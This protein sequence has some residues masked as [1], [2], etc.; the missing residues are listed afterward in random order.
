[1][2]NTVD[3][4]YQA[5]LLPSQVPDMTGGYNADASW[6][7]VWPSTLH[8]L[9]KAYGDA[10]I[11]QAYWA[12]LLAY[13][14][15]QVADM[16]GDIKK[17][18]AGLGD[19]CPPP[20]TP[21]IDDQGPKPDSAFSAGGTFLVDLAHVIEMSEAL[22]APDTPR[23]K[24]LWQTLAAQF[25]AA[26]AKNGGAYYGSS[27][28]DGAQTAQAQAIG[29]GVVPPQNLSAVAAY[30]VA[31]IAK[32]GGHTSVGIIGQ[33][34]L[35]RALTATGNG[36]AAIGMLLQTDYPSFGWQFNHPDEPSTTLWELWNAPNAGPS[37]NSRAHIMQGGV[38]A[39]LFTDVAGIAQAAGSA[40]YASLVLWPRATT[41][42]NLTAAAGSY[43]SIRGTVAVDWAAAPAAF[44]LRATVPAN[45]AAEVRLPFPAGAAPAALVATEGPSGAPCAAEAPENTSVRF[46]CAGGARITG[47]A[48]ASF[49]SPL[50]TCGGGF[51]VGA[52]NAANSSAVVASACVGQAEC[53][54]GANV[55][56][57]GDPC[58]GTKKWFSGAVTC[59]GVASNVIFANGTYVPGVPGV[60]G[61]RLDAASA[62][63]SVSVGSGDFAFSLQW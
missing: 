54:F 36:D 53:T 62:T 45:A 19:W 13:M 31:D 60:N 5:G 41:H 14:D 59:S 8:A 10:R 37:M 1:M 58:F 38:G 48:F 11:V 21:D 23:L 20:A 7:S 43:Q 52:C 17:I 55:T 15:K 34:Y 29:A 39:W 24:A 18:A 2:H 35:G 30:L 44:A 4:T 61:A 46:A 42:P 56:L 33:K 28:T 27:P 26:W 22:G 50:G 25:N 40:G 32:H 57:F 51:K 16:K 6:S 63:L 12:D 9:W 49:G 3:P 47:V